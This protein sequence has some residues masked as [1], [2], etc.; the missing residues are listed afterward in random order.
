M[1][2]IND[3]IAMIII[4]V[5]V[6]ILI[7]YKCN[8]KVINTDYFQPKIDMITIS[9][10][11]KNTIFQDN[12]IKMNNILI[13]KNMTDKK[14]FKHDYISYLVEPMTNDLLFDKSNSVYVKIQKRMLKDDNYAIDIIL[15]SSKVIVQKY[16]EPVLDNYKLSK[17]YQV[18]MYLNNKE[19][20][21]A[22]NNYLLD[23]CDVKNI[24]Y[25]T[26]SDHSKLTEEEYDEEKTQNPKPNSDEKNEAMIKMFFSGLNKRFER[27]ENTNVKVEDI[28]DFEIIK[29]V[30]LTIADTHYLFKSLYKDKIN[31]F[32]EETTSFYKIIDEYKYCEEYEITEEKSNGELHLHYNK[33]IWAINY[34]LIKHNKNVNKIIIYSN[35]PNSSEFYDKYINILYFRIGDKPNI[36]IDENIKLSIFRTE[37]SINKNYINLYYRLKSKIPLD[38]F[39]SDVINDFELFKENNKI[40]TTSKT[41]YHFNYIGNKK[42]SM[43]VLSV[44]NS[45]SELYETFEH[46]HNEHNEMFIKDL[47]KLKNLE[48]YKKNG[49]KRKK[50]YLFH[51]IPGSGKTSTV[52]A[53][54]LHDERH[55]IEVNFNILKTQ[56]EFEY[57]MNTPQIGSIPI[58]RNNI[59]LLFDEIECG[60]KKYNRDNIDVNKKEDSIGSLV[61][62]MSSEIIR[63]ESGE[64]ELDIAK[65]LSLLDGIGNYNG[66]VIVGTT[67]YVDKLDPAIYRELRLTPIHFRELRKCDVIGIIEKYFDAKMTESQKDR[68]KDRKISP[69]KC[70]HNC[71]VFEKES[72]DVLLDH[73]FNDE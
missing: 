39:T 8:I 50:G 44:S 71:Q 45:D 14:A 31:N 58:N 43:K 26:L 47:N 4:V 54:A 3:N 23:N 40:I 19:Y 2:N 5:I 7:L 65:I 61:S 64:N 9:H 38:K 34:Y 70:I 68:V 42:F 69:A 33:I 66:L 16:I 62:I 59:I 13:E 15:K 51:G 1:S 20:I 73:L 52:V 29:D 49:L 72:I 37:S 25:E 22:I 6:I 60:M 30:Y 21:K 41:L 24:V 11:F 28:K 36:K 55:I 27:K 10:E 46:L 67:N 12:F 18:K 17:Y 53:M 63:L 48:Y 35:N 57:I 32:I 56:D